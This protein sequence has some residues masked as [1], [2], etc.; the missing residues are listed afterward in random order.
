MNKQIILKNMNTIRKQEIEIL[1]E[2]LASV[3]TFESLRQLDSGCGDYTKERHNW[4]DS[5]TIEEI[6]NEIKKI[7][8][9]S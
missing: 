7:E 8:K 3:E 4:L 1:N 5:L 2:K 9:I 6:S